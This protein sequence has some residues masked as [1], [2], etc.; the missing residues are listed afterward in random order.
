MEMINAAIALLMWGGTV[1]I[2]GTHNGVDSSFNQIISEIKSG[3][4][5]YSHHKT[6]LDDALVDGLYQRICLMKG[7]EYSQNAE[8][9]W[10][11]DLI[12]MYPDDE[13]ANE[14]LFCIPKAS[15]GAF[16]NSLL[17]QARMRPEYSV[18][19]MEMPDEFVHKLPSERRYEIHCWLDENV[20]PALLGLDPYKRHY[21]GQDF[22]RNIDLTVIAV[23]AENQDLTRYCPLLIELG[24]MPFAQQ[25]E[26][27]DY[28]ARGIPMFTHAMMDARGNGQQMAEHV[29]DTFGESRVTQLKLTNNDYLELSPLYKKA[30]EDG[31]FYMPKDADIL[32]DHRMVKVIKGIAK[33]P[34]GAKEQRSSG[35]GVRHGDSYVALMLGVGAASMYKP[36]TTTIDIVKPDIY[37]RSSARSYFSATSVGRREARGYFV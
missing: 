10:R 8:D 12:N 23:I 34:D 27:F 21:I 19:R 31:A 4:L 30:L 7:R 24:N 17:V 3:K 35:R 1:R 6:T 15:G 36:G 29:A 22:G 16:L 2:I 20:K 5:N 26:I 37:S 14:E 18:L 9:K 11:M 33:I 28:I 13:A 25:E 32:S